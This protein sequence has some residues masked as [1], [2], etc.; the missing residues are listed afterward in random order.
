VSD[1]VDEQ[2]RSIGWDE[3]TRPIVTPAGDG[4]P[5]GMGQHLV[6]IHDMFRRE[7][8]AICQVRDQVRAGTLDISAL[9]QQI[10]DLTLRQA[11]EQLGTYCAQYCF[12][13]N[14][15]HSIEAAHVSPALRQYSEELAPVLDRLS[16]E[17]VTIHQVLVD[18]DRAAVRLATTREGFDEVDRL[19]DVLGSGLRSH[20]SYEESQLVA[21]LSDHRILI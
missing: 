10:H 6:L 15:H 11:F 18:L 21:P 9:R 16:A 17:H 7:L 5:Q 2:S 20:L 8:D 13:V 19:V 4:S 1:A 3:S 12:H 14:A